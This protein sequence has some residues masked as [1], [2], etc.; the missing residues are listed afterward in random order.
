M[1]SVIIYHNAY[2]AAGFGFAVILVLVTL[3]YFLEQLIARR[4]KQAAMRDLT[5]AALKATVGQHTVERRLD[6]PFTTGASLKHSS[7]RNIP[8]L[9]GE[10]DYSQMPG[11]MGYG[12]G[13]N[14]PWSTYG[15]QGR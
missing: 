5:V 7:D 1:F 15:G 9:S 10:S 13:T 12:A 6:K 11:Q 8:L 3:F 14:T 2:L 4:A